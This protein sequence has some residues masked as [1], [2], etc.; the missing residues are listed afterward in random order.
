MKIIKFSEEL[1]MR[2]VEYDPHFRQHWDGAS[3]VTNEDM[4]TMCFN[5]F[6]REY[7]LLTDPEKRV[8]REQIFRLIRGDQ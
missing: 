2:G 5:R 7:D 8:V 6:G 3:I 1:K 4:K